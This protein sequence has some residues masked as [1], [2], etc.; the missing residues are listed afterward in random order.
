MDDG[1]RVSRKGGTGGGGCGGHLKSEYGMAIS[2]LG[3]RRALVG[4]TW[5]IFLPP[6]MNGLKTVVVLHSGNKVFSWS[7]PAVS[8]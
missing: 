7:G 3:G 5:A 4:I 8:S 6:F 2:R 1:V